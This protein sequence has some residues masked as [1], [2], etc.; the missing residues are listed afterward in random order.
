LRQ[1]SNP[2]NAKPAKIRGTHKIVP[3]RNA[4]AIGSIQFISFVFGSDQYRGDIIA[5]REIK[6]GRRSAILQSTLLD[7]NNA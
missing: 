5:V 2:A 4:N 6:G 7:L 3:R 1:P